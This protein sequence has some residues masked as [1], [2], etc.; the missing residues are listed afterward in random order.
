M[1]YGAGCPVRGEDPP[2]P[3]HAFMGYGGLKL[4]LEP[5]QTNKQ[6]KKKTFDLPGCLKGRPGRKEA[7][8]TQDGCSVETVW[9][10]GAQEGP[11]S[12]SCLGPPA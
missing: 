12:K 1:S 2:T 10:G 5:N 6:N 9:Q 3:P 4:I 7:V 11:G 8:G